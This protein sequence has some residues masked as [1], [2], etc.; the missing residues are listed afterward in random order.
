MAHRSRD[1]FSFRYALARGLLQQGRESLWFDCFPNP[2]NFHPSSTIAFNIR[3]TRL[4]RFATSLST[5][6][7]SLHILF[8]FHP[9]FLC[10][11]TSIALCYPTSVLFLQA[12]PHLE[13]SNPPG[14]RPPPL[15]TLHPTGTS[16]TMDARPQNIGIK[17]IELYFPSQVRRTR[18]T[19]LRRHG[20]DHIPCSA[21][22]RPSLRSSMASA[23]ANTPLASARPR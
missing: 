7:Q 11:C 20:A 17:A 21:S 9:S 19:S 15:Y 13:P 12:S 8:S 10:D 23:Q 14:T 6:H 5:A 2:P 16:H 1:R 18:Y 4:L 22:T 3:L